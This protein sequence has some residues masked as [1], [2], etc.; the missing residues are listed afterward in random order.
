MKI[1]KLEKIKDLAYFWCNNDERIVIKGDLQTAIGTFD[2]LR[3]I[4]PDKLDVSA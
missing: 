4:Y 2:Q 3:D 1:P